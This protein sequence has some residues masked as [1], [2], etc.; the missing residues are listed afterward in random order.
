MLLNVLN[1][2]QRLLCRTGVKT[3]S[4]PISIRHPQ[5]VLQN[6]KLIHLRSPSRIII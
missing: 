1:S 2:S 6:Q 3:E 4:L 5:R